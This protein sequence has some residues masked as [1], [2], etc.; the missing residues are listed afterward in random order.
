MNKE[1]KTLLYNF[2][3]T[4]CEYFDGHKVDE[5]MPAF[6]DDVLQNRNEAAVYANN[7]GELSN[8]VAVS[9]NAV[10]PSGIKIAV[11]AL[12]KIAGE[13]S[14]KFLLVCE[15]IESEN[16][17]RIFSGEAAALLDKMLGAINLCRGKE[18][19]THSV[20]SSFTNENFLSANNEFDSFFN[21]QISKIKPEAVLAV[22]DFAIKILLKTNEE[23]NK[24]HGKFFD[25]KGLPLLAIFHPNSLLKDVNLKRPAWEDLKRFNS[26]IE[27]R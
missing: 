18:V 13:D 12:Q 25:F 27:K 21:E 10:E 9:A 24:L 26:K 3:K 1:E 19:F 2:F 22:G 15:W 23:I 20:N 4:A 11:S 7:T 5:L 6:E 8:S 16:S 14:R 17:E